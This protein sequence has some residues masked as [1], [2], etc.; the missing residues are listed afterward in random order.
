MQ[1]VIREKWYVCD[2]PHMH[3]ILK[4]PM[5]TQ[6]LVFEFYLY[7]VLS[8]RTQHTIRQA[9]SHDFLNKKLVYLV[10]RFLSGTREDFESFVLQDTISGLNFYDKIQ[11]IKE[12]SGNLV[13]RRT[14]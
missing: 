12:K 7:D 11:T 10:N 4:Q 5:A 9:T 8:F 1:L 6:H 2:P 3:I 14:N 13:W